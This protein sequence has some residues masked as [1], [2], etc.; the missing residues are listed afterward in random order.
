MIPID[1]TRWRELPGNVSATGELARDLLGEMH[2]GSGRA[3]QDLAAELCFQGT[4]SAVAY[5][6]V[7]HLVENVQ[8]LPAPLRAR[9]L[10]LVGQIA[11]SRA[12]YPSS[13]API[14]SDLRLDF[15]NALE[16]ARELTAGELRMQASSSEQAW[17]LL[18][19]ASAL[20]GESRM[21]LFLSVTG[22]ELLCPACGASLG[23]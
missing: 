1:S 7:P 10:G 20:Q 23:N 3:L 16:A 17:D 8:A 2:G 14:P 15:E 12:V 18:V 6:A 9:V 21:A 13:A 11:A 4:V 19:A 5:A 22:P